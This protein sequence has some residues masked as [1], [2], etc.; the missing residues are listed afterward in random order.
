MTTNWTDIL[1]AYSIEDHI[2]A[3]AY[4]HAGSQERQMLKTAM[5][6]HALDGESPSVQSSVLEHHK[7]GF[8]QR[9]HSAPAPTLF[10]LC[11]EEYTSPARLVGASMP[12]L[13][14]GVAQIVFMQIGATP[15]ALLVALELLGIEEA[16]TLP[17][18]HTAMQLFRHLGNGEYCTHNQRLL[19]L[20][21]GQSLHALRPIIED[22]H[23]PYY[24]EARPP[25]IFM[26]PTLDESMKKRIAFAQPDALIT[27]NPFDFAHAYY[28][29]DRPSQNILAQAVCQ[30]TALYDQHL[31]PH[32]EGCWHMLGL[33]KDFFL[34]HCM[35][36]GI[37]F[38]SEEQDER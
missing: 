26:A 22:V 8:W 13:L 37:T 36:C 33:Q 23:M 11:G 16:Y 28:G 30:G 7:Q 24:E 6:Y 15:P 25:R 9:K 29:I 4:E 27:P 21:P 5:A 34:N 32:M 31:G 14:A 35:M 17:D 20:H 10:I 2:R 3:E 1:K 18:I 19:L 38:D 12:A